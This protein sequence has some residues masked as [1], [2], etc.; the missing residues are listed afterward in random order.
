MIFS[1]N[2]A[3]AP[4]HTANKL[5]GTATAQKII[6]IFLNTSKENKFYPPNI[7]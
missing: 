1:L 3:S 2:V 4:N 5:D 7:E 6:K